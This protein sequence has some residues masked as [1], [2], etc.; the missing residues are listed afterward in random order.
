MESLFEA[1]YTYAS[2]NLYLPPE[3][4]E[5]QEQCEEMA[6]LAME[7]LT[8]KGCGSQAQRVEE[9]LETMCW[10]CQR[11]FFRAGLSIGLELNRL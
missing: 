5:E 2:G 10:F 7:E 6:R 1:L 9:G 11:S 3:E 8:A 4:L